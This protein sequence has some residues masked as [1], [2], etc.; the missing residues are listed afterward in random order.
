MEAVPQEPFPFTSYSDFIDLFNDRFAE[1]NKAEKARFKLKNLNQG[2]SSC[3]K[4]VASFETLEPLVGYN[5]G[6]LI[7]LFKSGLNKDILEAIYRMEL[8]PSTL[9]RW[10]TMAMRFDRQFR[11]LRETTRQNIVKNFW[12][13]STSKPLLKPFASAKPFV[14]NSRP[15]AP[16]APKPVQSKSDPNAMDVNRTSQ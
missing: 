15:T 3:E 13:G 6:A 4:Y 8:M 11:E 10:K 7:E 1:K 5:E 14:M 2:T 12:S 9:K 16:V